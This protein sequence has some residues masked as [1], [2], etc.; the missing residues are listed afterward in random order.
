MTSIIATPVIWIMATAFVLTDGT[1][2]IAFGDTYQSYEQCMKQAA[3]QNSAMK[4]DIAACTGDAC[5][6]KKAVADCVN[7]DDI[8]EV[9]EPEEIQWSKR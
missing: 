1:E 9:V 2:Y 8:E 6:L 4:D 3:V 7:V 5:V